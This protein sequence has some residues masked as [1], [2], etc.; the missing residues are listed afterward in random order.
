VWASSPTL[1]GRS[2]ASEMRLVGRNRNLPAECFA[3][4]AFGR[5]L[6]GPL[7]RWANAIKINHAGRS[8]RA[9]PLVVDFAP[10]YEPARRSVGAVRAHLVVIMSRTAKYPVIAARATLCFAQAPSQLSS[11]AY[12]QLRAERD[13]RRRA[14]LLTRWPRQRWIGSLTWS[15]ARCVVSHGPA[16]ARLKPL[17]F[18]GCHASP[19][20]PLDK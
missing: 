10:V 13:R 17:N 6:P 20:L 14:F 8:R 2:G 5:D 18:V 19:A 16:P 9:V 3:F 12:N 4:A 15:G 1:P 11:R 7:V